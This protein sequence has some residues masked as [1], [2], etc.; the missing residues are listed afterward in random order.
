[1]SKELVPTLWLEEIP[2][3]FFVF[4]KPFLND[5]NVIRF[6]GN[7]VKQCITAFIRSHLRYFFSINCLVLFGGFMKAKT[8]PGSIKP[9]GFCFGPGEI[10]GL[11]EIQ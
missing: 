6:K 4:V 8:E 11:G 3:H 5:L 7:Q 10:I 1:V 9:I 2:L